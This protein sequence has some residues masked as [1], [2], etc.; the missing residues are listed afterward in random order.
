MQK[1]LI[2]KKVRKKKETNLKDV[3]DSEKYLKDD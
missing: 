3:D 2:E 1:V